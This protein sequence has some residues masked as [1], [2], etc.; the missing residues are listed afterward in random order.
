MKTG[1][2][3]FSILLGS[4]LLSGAI[5]FSALAGR[6]EFVSSGTADF[7]Q[8]FRFDKLT[9]MSEYAKGGMD[10]S[11]WMPYAQGLR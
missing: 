11:T 9:G 6:Y 8:Q 5:V 2:L 10:N 7:Y 1:W 3:G 4:I